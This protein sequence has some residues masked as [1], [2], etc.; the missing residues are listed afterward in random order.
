L[1]RRIL[2]ASLGGCFLAATQRATAGEVRFERTVDVG[3]SRVRVLVDETTVKGRQP[4]IYF[5]PHENE[6]SC[7][8]VTRHV[9]SQFGGR[10]VEIRSQGDRFITFRFKG[11]T[12]T[13][14]PNRMFTDAGLQSSLAH[15]APMSPGPLESVL[16]LRNAVL[17]Q[18]G[19]GKTPIIAV[20]NN[21]RD[22]VTVYS[23]QKSGMFAAQAAQVAI[24]TV[25]NPRNFFLALD[26]RVFLRLRQ[27]GFNS[28]LYTSSAPDD[29]SLA[30]F[31]RQHRWQYVNVETAEGN[32]HDQERMMD[33]LQGVM[34]GI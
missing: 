4:L 33:A 3:E 5:H 22:S 27:R 6:H 15:F 10:L 32:M 11:A 7:A 25:E 9:I 29:G 28:I 21:S 12:Y 1:T 19:K 17:N 18:L 24:N 20:H 13:F 16:N 26:E 34:T 31:C 30:F 14:D 23:F 8:V 2:L